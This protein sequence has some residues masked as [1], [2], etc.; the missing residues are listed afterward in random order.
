MRNSHW[1]GLIIGLVLALSIV[2]LSS[3][4]DA[5]SDRVVISNFKFGLVC[6]PND[7]RRICFQTRDIQITGESR[8]IYNKQA[9]A[10]TWYG[11]SFDYR[12]P[13]DSIKIQCEAKSNIATNVGSPTAELQKDSTYTKYEIELHSDSRHF[14]NPQYSSGFPANMMGTTQEYTQACSYRGEKLFEFTLLLHY[15]ES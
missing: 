2:T 14:F 12:L 1:R 13:A 3:N 10:C 8:C 7:N 15:P 4:A 5:Q 11:Y 9:V 6:G